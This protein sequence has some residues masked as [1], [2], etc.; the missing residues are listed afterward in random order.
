MAY[1]EHASAWGRPIGI[2]GAGTLDVICTDVYGNTEG[3]WIYELAPFEGLAG[4]FSLDPLFCD[5]IGGDFTINASSP[6]MPA[7]NECGI[8][9]G[10]LGEGCTLSA[11][12]PGDSA[13]PCP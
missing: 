1:N 4:N 8:L 11:A 6:C 3:D 7:N 5:W 10:A 9:I 13:E 2:S 12:P